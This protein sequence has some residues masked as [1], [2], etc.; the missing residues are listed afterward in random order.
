[1]SPFREAPRVELGPLL[2]GLEAA[3]NRAAVR[4]PSGGRLVAHGPD[5]A[6]ARSTGVLGSAGLLLVGA[7]ALVAWGT[8]WQPSSIADLAASAPVVVFGGLSLAAVFRATDR[9][10]GAFVRPGEVVGKKA[11]AIL[12]R[13]GRLEVH[14]YRGCV[15]PGRV[16]ALRRALA[17]AVDPE[18]ASWIPADVRGRA[19]LLLARE[20]AATSGPAWT[21]RA[22]RREGA[23]L[24]VLSLLAAAAAHLDDD[25]PARADLAALGRAT[26]AAPRPSRHARALELQ[27]FA[28][29]VHR[30]AD[31]R[32]E[33]AEDESLDVA[34]APHRGLHAGR[35]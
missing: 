10:V 7:T 27:R 25:T 24:E 3:A 34:V 8:G 20:I 9:A 32:D 26:D 21:A 4:L 17:A 11:R 14:A 13:L 35:W 29:P 1:M 6:S 31:A 2:V 30:V 15:D 28:A 22:L 12:R 5:G 19:E 33:E 16:S 23:R 18:V